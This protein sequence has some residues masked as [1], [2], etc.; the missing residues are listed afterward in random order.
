LN[1]TQRTI[2]GII[3]AYAAYIVGR[4][5]TIVTTAILARILVPGDFGL[6]GFSL[7]LLAFMEVVRGFGIND[8]LI[9]TDDNLE[10]A[11]A[12]AFVMNIGIG[13]VQTLVMVLLAPLSTRFFDDSR[14]VDVIR[15]MSLTFLI[16]GLGRTHDALLQKELEFRRRFMPDLASAI[17]KG[18]ASIALAWSGAGVW[19]LV[20]GNLVGAA[21]RTL[22]KW[23]VLGWMP[24]LKFYIDRARELWG[25]GFY[26]LGFELLNVALEQADQFMIGTFLGAVQLGYYTIAVR[27]PE[28]VI[29]NFSI[30]LTRV[31]FPS[32]AKM[33]DD[34]SQLIA[35]FLGTTK[36]TAFVTVPMGLG[37]ATVAPELIRVVFGDQWENSINFLRVLA[38]L[39]TMVTLPWS[40][41]DVLKAIG[42]P[43]ISTKMLL[44]EALYTFP[45][46]FGFVYITRQAIMASFANLIALTITAVFRLGIISRVLEISPI[47]FGKVFRGSF[48]SGST[49]VLTVTLWRAALSGGSSDVIILSTSILIGALTY[50]VVLYLLER[51]DLLTARD[52]L[53]AT[54]NRKKG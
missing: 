8:A 23:L 22:G 21:T 41:G 47:V 17:I 10:D 49:M 11:A 38:L 20:I 39:G 15:L 2:K 7:V 44:I 6:I 25:Y 45:L 16:D 37:M 14:I 28:M 31:I 48:V 53:V 35:G 30:V 19:S 33:K 24:R 13:A 51:D 36:Y 3:W 34:R 1:L 40:A 27:I 18:I 29:A 32:F 46:I 4:L 26:I 42:R 5:L 50:G 12:T 9:Y 43:D 54:L 52:T